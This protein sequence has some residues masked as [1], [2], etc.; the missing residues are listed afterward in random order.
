MK[1]IPIWVLIPLQIIGYLFAI[2]Q[3]STHARIIP[4]YIIEGIII[5]LPL[6][7]SSQAA[8]TKYTSLRE[9]IYIVGILISIVTIIVLLLTMYIMAHR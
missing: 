6:F 8:N 7:V 3:G 9:A 5:V 4:I 1:I 2:N